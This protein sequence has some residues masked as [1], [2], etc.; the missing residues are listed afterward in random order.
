MDNSE[1][2]NELISYS[3]LV[4]NDTIPITQCVWNSNISKCL[5]AYDPLSISWVLMLT[6][7]LYSFVFSVV[8]GNCSKV[9]Q[10][11]SIT[12]ELYGWLFYYLFYTSD[13]KS[14]EFNNKGYILCILITIWGIRLTYNFWRRGGYGNFFQHEEDYRWP[15]LRKF[16]NNTFLFLIFNISFIS[17]YQNFLLWLLALPIYK[18][19]KSKS[20]INDYDI[21]LIVIFLLLLIFETIADEQHYRFH[22]YKN[23]ISIEERLKHK[24]E[25]IRNGFYTQG[26]FKYCRHP[27]Y[28]CEQGIWVTLY[29]FTVQK[30]KLYN[31]T[32]L[33]SA[34]LILLFQGSMHFSESI[35]LSKYKEYSKYKNRT[36]QCIPFPINN[37]K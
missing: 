37:T 23:S 22:T 19:I 32:I 28:F 13:V 10:I 26:L 20:E 11:W 29:L 27:N 16:I 8:S 5:H 30:N 14:T 1:L 6:I 34:L 9:D 25:D 33:G 35:T 2:I 31:F 24:N 3:N 21:C 15:I 4:I 36:P 18:V 7:S 17:F 12:P